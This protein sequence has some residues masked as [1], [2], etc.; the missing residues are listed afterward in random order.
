MAST[1]NTTK[2][3]RAFYKSARFEAMVRIGSAAFSAGTTGGFAEVIAGEQSRWGALNPDYAERKKRQGMSAEKWI[4]TGRT[5]AALSQGEL[6]RKEGTTK[7]ARYK[8]SPGR[9][10]ATLRPVAFRGSG[11]GKAP[12]PDAQKRIWKNLNYGIRGG[13]R[14]PVRSKSGR[15][16]SGLPARSLVPWIVKLRAKIE[17][18]VEAE[19]QKILNDEGIGK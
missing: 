6:R 16:I 2:M 4:R 18:H 9:L 19:L 15:I 12:G 11:K 7:K 5:V 8:V 14:G 3:D 10:I 17:E 1:I 13:K